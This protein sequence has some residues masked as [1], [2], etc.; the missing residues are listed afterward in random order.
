MPMWVTEILKI[1]SSF[2]ATFGD[3]SAE[4][5]HLEEQ[6][7]WSYAN[8]GLTQRICF[9]TDNRLFTKTCIS[10]NPVRLR[11]CC[12]RH[13]YVPS[14]H[15]FWERHNRRCIILAISI[16]LRWI[17]DTGRTQNLELYFPNIG[18]SSRIENKVSSSATVYQVVPFVLKGAITT[19]N[20][21][22]LNTITVM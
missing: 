19:K 21:L 20:S 22:L 15:W 5:F 12:A 11:S 7:T 18:T 13:R 1:I 2:I 3:A 8:I 16:S 17:G 10:W 9:P 4:N 6:F 14:E